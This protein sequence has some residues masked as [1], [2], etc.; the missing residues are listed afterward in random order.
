M[1][2]QKFLGYLS[3][4]EKGGKEYCRFYPRR[5]IKDAQSSQQIQLNR[6][7]KRIYDIQFPCSIFYIDPTRQNNDLRNPNERNMLIIPRNNSTG[8]DDYTISNYIRQRLRNTAKDNPNFDNARIYKIVN[9]RLDNLK[10]GEFLKEKG[11]SVPS[12]QGRDPRVGNY[13]VYQYKNYSRKS[14]V[15]AYAY[16]PNNAIIYVYFLGA[17]KAW[18]KYDTKSAPSYVI[19]EMIRRAKNGWGLNRYINKHPKT[20]YWKGHY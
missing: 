2:K 16:S 20:Y 1:N 10:V 8:A 9:S 14:G 3:V 7:I 15:Y 4:Y 13:P 19:D 17:N 6:D 11:I 18:Y 5:S 12:E